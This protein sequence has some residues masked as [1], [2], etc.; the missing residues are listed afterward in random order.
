MSR[1]YRPHKRRRPQAVTSLEEPKVHND[2]NNEQ[3]AEIIDSMEVDGLNQHPIEDIEDE[4]PVE[5]SQEPD[6]ELKRKQ[7]IWEAFQEEHHEVLEQLPLSLQRSYSLTSELDEQVTIDYNAQILSTFK[8]YVALRKSLAARPEPPQKIYGDPM[9]VDDA[10]DITRKSDTGSELVKEDALSAA[11]KPV[12]STRELLVS[13]AQMA[14]ETVDRYARDLDREVQEQEAAISI[15][16]RPGTHAT[17]IILPEIMPPGPRSLKPY[18]TFVTDDLEDEE[19]PEEYIE[20]EPP[21]ASPT[22][23]LEPEETPSVPEPP[24]PPPPPQL[25]RKTRGKS[26]KLRKSESQAPHEMQV[27]LAEPP[28]DVNLDEGIPEKPTT[29]HRPTIR[30][31]FSL[32]PPPPEQP[33]LP[34]QEVDANENPDEK[35]YCICNGP[36]DGMVNLHVLAVVTYAA[37]V[38]DTDAG[39]RQ[40]EMRA[41]VVPF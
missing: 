12:R 3:H 5:P 25:S 6:E 37:D 15:G 29:P 39:V 23:P 16:M 26:K 33:Q 21:P 2:T 30:L 1:K 34:L 8:E 14:D 17:K 38:Y 40:S 11:P 19:L 20:I 36:S 41:G 9:E 31:T 10:S 22:P 32:P 27:T 13:I 28:S 35:L 24:P 18:H 7:E 4:Q